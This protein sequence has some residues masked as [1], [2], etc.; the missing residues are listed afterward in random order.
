MVM[1]I[2]ALA[3][4]CGITMA[5]LETQ[6]ISTRLTNNSSHRQHASD[7]AEAGAQIV[8]QRMHSA[9]WSGVGQAI[10][11]RLW[12]SAEGIAEYEAT[13]HP[14]AAT[15]TSLNR[16]LQVEVRCVG[17]FRP[18]R[19]A[20]AVSSRQITMIV[21]L[22]PRVAAPGGSTS[23]PSDWSAASAGSIATRDH[24]M[25]LAS[26]SNSALVLDPGDRIEGGVWMR[27]R[28]VIYQDPLWSSSTRQLFL[29]HVA[30]DYGPLTSIEKFPHPLGGAFLFSN[31]GSA[32]NS[33]VADTLSRLGV[34]V[35]LTT[36]H[37]PTPSFSLSQWSQY[38]LYD[39]G[40]L[41]TAQTLGSSVQA[42]ELKPT[43]SNPLGIYIRSGDLRISGNTIVVGTLVVTGRV[44]IEG[45]NN[46]LMP[47]R[48]ES[49]VADD[50]RS[51]AL[52]TTLPVIMAQ[53][54]E[55][56]RECY[57]Q[58][59]GQLLAT[60]TVEGAGA[61]PRIRTNTTPIGLTGTQATATAGPQPYS[62]IQIEDNIPFE[63]IQGGWKHQ[64]CLMTGGSG[65]VLPI[66]SVDKPGRK[67][68]V[69]GHVSTTG[70]VAWRMSRTPLA[71]VRIAGRV[72]C[73][74]ADFNRTT[75]WEVSSLSWILLRSQWDQTNSLLA[76]SGQPS[77][78][79]TQWLANP[80]NVAWL[81]GYHATYGLTI[82]PT[83]HLQK[84][85]V[86][87]EVTS[88]PVF[89]ASTV[90]PAGASIAGISQPGYQWRVL[91]KEVVE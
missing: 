91:S 19:D 10:T 18:V 72:W 78:T 9:G 49:L 23:T 40:F 88:L 60:R 17:R 58:V 7:A 52:P 85:I 84:Q 26:N 32:T 34:P 31:T 44:T 89:T 61:S 22:R 69:A 81:G 51:S 74:T 24:A 46:V 29:N 39:K 47:A 45:T 76:A 80:L 64:I 56:D 30:Q 21:E 82:D 62:T 42:T 33:T 77:M 68:T 36:S 71:E 16:L 13:F 87:N 15:S 73:D 54:I 35:Q 63:S 4:T 65:R 28:P 25:S 79:L 59:E 43:P 14:V 55:F 50:L 53:F 57:C 86:A 6:A 12:Q 66:L 90:T 3:L 27:G 38:R 70:P 1:V 5:F 11:G 75:A 67:I 2:V 37:P 41:Y 8:L 48:L 83:F 20:G